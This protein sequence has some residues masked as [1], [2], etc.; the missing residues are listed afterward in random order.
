MSKFLSYAN[1]LEDNVDRISWTK[2]GIAGG[3]LGNFVNIFC[4]F[5]DQIFAWLSG[6]STH[7]NVALLASTG[8]AHTVAA[9]KAEMQR[10][11]MAIANQVRP[12]E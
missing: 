1:L 12:L 7:T 10:R 3:T 2:V 9:G 4:Q 8:I 6:G 11:T 5:G